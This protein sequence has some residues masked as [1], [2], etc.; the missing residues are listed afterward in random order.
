MGVGRSV[1]RHQDIAHPSAS[2]YQ[3][4]MLERTERMARRMVG[5]IEWDCDGH[6]SRIC[7]SEEWS[8]RKAAVEVKITPKRA[9]GL[10]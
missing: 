10:E 4:Q 6:F 3:R 5:D 2:A 7:W 9:S 8:V 1:R